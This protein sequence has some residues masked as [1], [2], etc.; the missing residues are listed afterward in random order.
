MDE[1]RHRIVFECRCTMACKGEC[2]HRIVFECMCERCV[3]VSI[4]IRLCL[5]VGAEWYVRVWKCRSKLCLRVLECMCRMVWVCE[6]T[7]LTCMS[8]WLWYLT[9]YASVI[10]DCARICL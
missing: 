2:R 10:S 3:R 7:S 6:W 1:S 8:V 9:V 5:N 4:D